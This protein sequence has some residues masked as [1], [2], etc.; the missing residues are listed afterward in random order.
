M[1]RTHVGTW[2]PSA[3]WITHA[4]G[5]V[6]LMASAAV[7]IAPLKRPEAPAASAPAPVTTFTDPAAATLA[8]WLGPGAVR[9]HV[10]VLGLAT[11]N[12]RSVALLK[13]NDAPPRAFM[14]GETLARGVTLTAIEPDGVSIARE[15]E[16]MRIAAPT[17]QRL[18]AGWVNAR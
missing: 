1:N 15:G 12:D 14:P 17:Q 13:I 7:W 8:S 18:T 5:A 9:I 6:G 2:R 11:R 10:V 3:L 4:A 16:V